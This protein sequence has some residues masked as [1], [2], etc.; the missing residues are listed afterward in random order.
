MYELVTNPEEEVTEPLPTHFGDM[1]ET[2]GG[3]YVANVLA[4][5]DGGAVLGLGTHRY[6]YGIRSF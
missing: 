2:L 1:R 4:R 6:E 3:E 5:P